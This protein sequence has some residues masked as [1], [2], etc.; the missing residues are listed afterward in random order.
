MRIYILPIVLSCFILGCSK[1]NL[2]IN[3]PV[4]TINTNNE[5]Y[6]YITNFEFEAQQR[7]INL[8]ITSSDLTYEIAEIDEDNVAGVCHYNS[9][10][11]NH[12]IL[13]ETFWNTASAAFVGHYP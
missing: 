11:P 1:E 8:N 10:Y 7:G 4:N 13:D 2:V 12:I 9:A 5:L 6:T 3:E